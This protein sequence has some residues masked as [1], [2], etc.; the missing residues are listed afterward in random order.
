MLIT[1]AHSLPSNLHL[2]TSYKIFTDGMTRC[3]FILMIFLTILMFQISLNY[4]QFCLVL[5][6]TGLDWSESMSQSA[7][8]LAFTCS[9]INI[10]DV[11]QDM[12]E[13]KDDEDP[14]VMVH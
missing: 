8:S 3:L 13:N 6:S 5:P 7:G 9:V 4:M 1:Y 2:A 10:A 14:E 11:R 12:M